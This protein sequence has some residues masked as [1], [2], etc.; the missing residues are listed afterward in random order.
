MSGA[1]RRKYLT[2]TTLDQALLDWQADCLDNRLEMVVDIQTPTGYIYASDRNKYV[3]GVFYEALLNFPV[4]GRTVG[5]WLSATV[6][7]SQLQLELSNVDGRFNHI[8]QQGADYGGW[9]GKTVTVKV[10]LAEL[11]STYQPIFNGLITEIGGVLRSVKSVTIIARDRYEKLSKNFPN[12]YLSQSVYPYLEDG[13]VGKALPYIY[14]DYTI[15]LNPAAA[16]VPSYPLNGKDPNVIGGETTP[17]GPPT[18]VFNNVKFRISDNPLPFFDTAN[19]WFKK[20]DRY[21]RCPDIVNVGADNNSFE[22]VQQLTAWLDG[23]TYTFAQ[24]DTFLVQVKGKDLSGYN[25]NIVAQAK[26][27]LKTFGGAVDAD[28]DSNWATY[29]NKSTPAQSAIVNIKSRVWEN[30]PKPALDYALSML[31]QV[32][33]E[34]FIDRS[35]M[36]KINSLQF[37]DFNASPSFV[38]KNWDVAKDTFSPQ[39]D[40]RNNFNRVQAA[41]DFHPDVADNARNTPIYHN[42]ASITQV[43]KPISKL[44]AFPNLYI[45]T[46]V[47]NQVQEILKMASAMFE[48]INVKLTWR[49]LLLDIGDFVKLNV[50]IGG[51]IFEDVP[52]MIR[53]VGYDSKGLSIPIIGWSFALCPFPGYTPT[54][55]GT[56][57]GYNATIAQE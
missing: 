41:Y 20:S 5:D 35:L 30:E 33:L 49:A 43:G 12:T 27:I 1:D 16:I 44:I 15:N 18:G 11:G 2:S 37:E 21:F 6:K 28:F 53:D 39:L 32:R 57:G 45:A 36:I 56:V 52:V 46:D 17:S 31:A 25:D 50:Q 13:L 29:M 42:A 34:A 54:Y 47:Q 8:L 38:V 7:F 55:G 3:D 4:I 14:G 22:V 40:T 51:T 23:S 48:I 19:V 24:G 26:D 9:V 10:G